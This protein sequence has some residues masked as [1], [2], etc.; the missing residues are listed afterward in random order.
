MN[1]YNYIQL[2]P[3][4]QP[5]ENPAFD[6]GIEV[7]VPALAGT[8]PNLDH[9]GALEGNACASKQALD[10]SLPHEGATLATIR[11]DLDSVTAMAVITSRKVGK[12]FRQD[13]SAILND[14]EVIDVEGP[15][16]YEKIS[17][18]SRGLLREIGAIAADMKTDLGARV[19]TVMNFIA[20]EAD[21]TGLSKEY[22]ASL[23]KKDDEELQAARE[24][25][26]IRVMENGRAVFVKSTH[27][28]ATRLGYE[29]SPVVIA[30]NPA[31]PVL[32]R[33]EDG[34]MKPTGETY[35]KYTICR[36]SD[37]VQGHFDRMLEELQSLEKGW[38]G[39]GSIFGSPQNRSS[40]L[41]EDQVT[42][43]VLK[44]LD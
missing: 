38:G 22:V 19:Q 10:C 31:M 28:H 42:S 24:K 26:D 40:T 44:N 14:L 43:I 25:S 17:P 6:L 4:K 41:T 34:S 37:Q 32:A 30:M 12:S 18:A 21:Q 33:Q 15:S 2:D 20:E 11:P 7:T 5:E 16:A 36:Y 23:L 29:H 8:T 3:R 39:R 9:H 27:R 1:T 35:V 13:I